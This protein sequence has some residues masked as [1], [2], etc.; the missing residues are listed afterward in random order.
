M[1]LNEVLEFHKPFLNTKYTKWYLN[2]VSTD[3]DEKYTEKHHI[4]PKSIFPQYKDC[5]WNLVRLSAR[6]HFIAH[7][8]L[9]KMFDNLEFQRKMSWSVQKIKGNNKYFNSKLYSIVK[10]K[11][12]G[13][14][15]SEE[16][17]KKVSVTKLS[18]KLKYSD[19]HKTKISL[20]LKGIV[21][22]PMS[23]EQKKKMIA[24]K[25]ANYI[26]K[27]WM[28]KDGIQT[29]VICDDV[30]NYLQNGWQKGIIGKHITKE[31]K[32]KLSDKSKEQW[33]KIKE[34]GHQDQLTGV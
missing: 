26:A 7:I 18:Q 4:L 19:E 32:K 14:G 33:K 11:L 1:V 16:N 15:Q 29:K 30:N 8:L 24:S 17:K 28:N 2:I 10:K 27:I 3:S 23:E 12:S 5:K 13:I 6:Q 21:R 22:G 34:F 31:Y 9:V 25:K 20:S